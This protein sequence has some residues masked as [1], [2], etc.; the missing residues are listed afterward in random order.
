MEDRVELPRLYLA[1]HTVKQYAPDDAALSV[2]AYVLTSAKDSRLT[3]ELVYQRQIAADVSAYE[4]GGRLD[5]TLRIIATARPGHALPELQQVTDSVIRRL[6]EDGPTRRELQQAKNSIEASFLRS[7]ERVASVANRLNAYYYMTGEPDYFQADLDRY[8]A[9]TPADIQRVAREYLLNAHRVVLSVVPTGKTGLALSASALL[10][11]Q[12]AG[13]GVIDPTTPPELGPPPVLHIPPVQ[14]A[15]LPN[16]VKLYLVEMHE[17]PLV[18]WTLTVAGGGR[19]D[20]SLP[21]LASFTANMLDEG[22]DTLDAFGI[23]A[24]AAY[25]GASLRTG[26][27]WD[28]IAVWLS[29][30]R[31]T[32]DRALDLMSKVALAPTFRGAD[33]A[34]QRSLRLAEILQQ[35]AQPTVVASLTSYALLYP[36]GH[37]YHASLTGDSSSTAALDSAVVRQF[38]RSVFRPGRAHLIVTGDITLAQARAAAQR[39]FGS[40]KNSGSPPPAPA[41]AP[42]LPKPWQG[43]TTVYLVDKPGAAQSVI[44]IGAPG[45]SRR[46]PD[47]YA[48]EVMNTIL[49]GSFSSR[50]NQ[51]L[52]ETHGYTYGA[53]SG[54]AYRPL[55]GPWIASSSVRTDVTDSS[56]V[57][58]FREFR[59]IRDSAVSS[60]ELRRAKS[61][62]AL[63]LGSEFETT[64]QMAGHIDDLLEFGLPLDYYNSYTRGIMAVTAADVQRVARTYLQ[65]GH[66]AV[67]VVGDIAKIRPGIEALQLGPVVVQ[68]GQ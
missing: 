46:S 27:D 4:D 45:V 9:V 22:A 2:L 23:A 37:P 5:G 1:W 60:V 67:V 57:E 28:E 61:Y 13:P 44:R 66:L 63:G 43:N 6:A 49:G 35:R 68:D 21:G 33:I 7:L 48:I 16:G 50:I 55:P 38:Y 31:R 41:A 14:T 20:D 29:V 54:F 39:Y 24:Q 19:E 64:S 36:E 8:R 53:G 47:Y 51:N 11:Q 34:R 32:M 52:R 40:W 56:L 15:E 25:L 42:S 62:I 65:P 30:P 58:F 26:S 12:P 10:A 3:R 59:S 17:V 18:Q